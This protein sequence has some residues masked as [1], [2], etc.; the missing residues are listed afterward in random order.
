MSLEPNF[1]FT[2]VI[3]TGGSSGIG[4]SFI[5]HIGKLAPEV[6]ICNLSRRS[7]DHNLAQLKLRHHSVDLGNIEARRSVLAEVL[8]TIEETVPTGRVLLINNAGFGHYGVFPAGGI[9]KQLEILE[10]NLAA[11]L[12]VTAAC[13]PLI[14]ARGGTILN[15]ASVTAFQ[16][17]PFIATYGATKAF[18]LQWGYSLG[19]ELRSRGVKV[20]TVCPG[21]TRTAFHRSAGMQLSGPASKFEQTSDEVV[22]E[23]M[24]ALRHGKRHIVTGWSNRVITSIARHLPLGW[25]ARLSGRVLAHLRRQETG[26]S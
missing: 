21:S 5:E 18:L 16:P 6:L 10:V 7:P 14:E 19:E 15:V 3:L 25:A 20:L 12:D 11:V 17:T 9:D 13:L 4:K 26:S 2:S 8:R 1:P 23:A 22:V 24:N